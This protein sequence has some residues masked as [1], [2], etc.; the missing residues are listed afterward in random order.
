MWRRRRRR[1]RR[2]ATMPNLWRQMVSGCFGGCLSSSAESKTTASQLSLVGVS[3]FKYICL[4]YR[5]AY[6]LTTAGDGIP[7]VVFIGA[8]VL[9]VIL[10]LGALLIFFF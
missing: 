8:V 10:V 1:R 5:F 4:A 2:R 7:L 6:R 3:S 9:G